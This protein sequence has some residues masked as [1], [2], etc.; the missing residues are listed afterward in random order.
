MTNVTKQVAK[1]YTLMQN[2]FSTPVH[3]DK[4][5]VSILIRTGIR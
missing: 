5:Y 3:I 2:N 4:V 1:Y